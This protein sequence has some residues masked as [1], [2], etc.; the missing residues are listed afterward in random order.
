L[1]IAA[2]DSRARLLYEF[3]RNRMQAN[4]RDDVIFKGSISGT[5]SSKD[6]ISRIR[7]ARTAFTCS[8][9][10]PYPFTRISRAFFRSRL[11]KVSRLS[12]SFL[13]RASTIFDFRPALLVEVEL[14]R[15]D[16]HALAVDGVGE[17]VDLAMVRAHI[18]FAE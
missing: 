15:H 4:I 18:R 11:F 8:N 5:R 12:C 17:P 16:G 9:R 10:A 2:N 1:F 3:R 6:S 13:P 7:P 14:E